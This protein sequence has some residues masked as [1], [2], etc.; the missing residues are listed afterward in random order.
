MPVASAACRMASTNLGRFSCRRRFEECSMTMWDTCG[1]PATEWQRAEEADGKSIARPFRVG[2]GCGVMGR[3]VRQRLQ[4]AQ[5]GVAPTL[6]LIQ[7]VRGITQRE[8]V[9]D[10]GVVQ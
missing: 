10:V 1:P 7:A 6:N 2:Q 5:Q 9:L 4:V 3:S 8:Q